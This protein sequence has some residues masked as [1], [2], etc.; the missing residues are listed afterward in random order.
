MKKKNKKAPLTTL[1]LIMHTPS[2]LAASLMNYKPQT[3]QLLKH[4]K[5]FKDAYKKD[6]RNY[7]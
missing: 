6:L 1:E 3:V 2:P 7:F 5:K 4:K